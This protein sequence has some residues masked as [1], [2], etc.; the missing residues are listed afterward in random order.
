MPSMRDT[1]FTS[2][3]TVRRRQGSTIRKY[4]AEDRQRR[5]D[6]KATRDLKN[7]ISETEK[8][9]KNLDS[10]RKTGKLPFTRQELESQYRALENQ[11]V[12]YTN[13]AT[14]L[15]NVGG[16][17]DTVI[18]IEELIALLGE[19]QQQIVEI[20]QADIK[21]EQSVL[22]DISAFAK[23]AAR[24]KILVDPYT[25]FTSKVSG[26]IK[27]NTI[28]GTMA[29]AAVSASSNGKGAGAIFRATAGLNVVGG[30]SGIDA[31]KARTGN[32]RSPM[33]IIT[34]R[35]TDKSGNNKEA[36]QE[37]R[38][39]NNAKIKA[40]KENTDAVIKAM[41]E[42]NRLAK[43]KLEFDEEN[44]RRLKKVMSGAAGGGAAA[45]DNGGGF[46]ESLLTGLGIGSVLKGGFGR[47]VGGVARGV[48]GLARGAVGFGLKA[49]PILGGALGAAQMSLRP[50]NED[51][52][53]R[54]FFG[55]QGGEGLLDS[56]A[57]NYAELA[58]GGAA[59]G[60]FLPGIGTLIGAG[61]GTLTAAAIDYWDETKDVMSVAAGVGVPGAS[62]FN[63]FG[64]G[65]IKSEKETNKQF[66][67]ILKDA[68]N[69]SDLKKYLKPLK[70]LD[71]MNGTAM[72]RF[73]YM[74]RTAGK[75][76]AD[77]SA[78][79]SR[80]P[81]YYP[82][83]TT[84][85]NGIAIE[86]QAPQARAVGPNGEDLGIYDPSKP[87]GQ[88][89]YLTS[90]AIN[91]ASAMAS[92]N[93]MNVKPTAN[94]GISSEEAYGMN[95]LISRGMTPEDAAAAMGNAKW[96]SNLDPTNNTGDG[97]KAHGLFQW[98]DRSK[99]LKEFAAA[100]G[101]PWTDKDTQYEFMLHEWNG[102]ESSARDRVM[103]AQ[104]VEEKSGMFGLTFER[105]EGATGRN[106][107][108]GNYMAIHG[109]KNRM[110][111]SRRI[112]DGYKASANAGSYYNP[113]PSNNPYSNDM[114]SSLNESF[115]GGGYT[116]DDAIVYPSLN[117]PVSITEDQTSL[118]A[119][120]YSPVVN[121]PTPMTPM[122]EGTF[123]R[124]GGL[125]GD[126]TPAAPAPKGFKKAPAVNQGAS[127][128]MP[129]LGN[130]PSNDPDLALF[131]LTHPFGF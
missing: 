40:D 24:Q 21:F 19:Y 81:G 103:G 52:S 47:A 82:E 98:N 112:Y 87:I 100:R 22:R 48:G 44:S 37:S 120:T 74:G 130:T 118:R 51:G 121:V 84:I 58:A 85:Y 57:A 42:A 54:D 45:N 119:N 33:D 64:G 89:N 15:K 91:T 127:M 124:S 97:G 72:D 86:G 88:K 68:I 4:N 18:A 43:E 65:T 70:A 106:I 115:L 3:S 101:K 30:A 114:R 53:R 131:L 63:A 55:G 9:L 16:E 113:Q 75:D 111:H 25:A 117:T 34:D 20:T 31:L 23:D 41:W 93:G 108:S 78:K 13:Q 7:T 96:E 49:L 94:S 67:T 116:R 56:R 126:I 79:A 105:P 92:G 36:I 11:I 29:R 28:L 32:M 125:L 73:G 17:A 95:Y 122:K 104:T 39:Q 5:L 50:R 27:S 59:A 80:D 62:I 6:S 2:R 14:T 90:G 38:R 83:G 128:G 77:A 123:E 8:R 66:A 1:T 110:E 10:V 76:I 26:V 107:R 60:S 69:S 12:Y 99:K 46:F 129:T 102:S 71:Y 35:A 109:A 61:L